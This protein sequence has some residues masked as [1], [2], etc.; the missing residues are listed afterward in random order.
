LNS[1]GNVAK[2]GGSFSTI[3]EIPR[4]NSEADYGSLDLEIGLV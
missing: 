1:G 3:Y 2:R 4:K